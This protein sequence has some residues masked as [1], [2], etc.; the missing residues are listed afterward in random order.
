MKQDCDRLMTKS[1]DMSSQENLR[2]LKESKLEF[3][4]IQKSL[5]IVVKQDVPQLRSDNERLEKSLNVLEMEQTVAKGVFKSTQKNMKTL[6]LAQKKTVADV[7]KLK[8][9]FT[10]ACRRRGIYY[11]LYKTRK[12]IVSVDIY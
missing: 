11:T 7:K 5:D 8:S 2:V 1:L 10:V 6:Q 9:K 12:K 3:K 4:S